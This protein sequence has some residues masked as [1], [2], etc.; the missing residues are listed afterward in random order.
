M[1]DRSVTVIAVEGCSLL[2]ERGQLFLVALLSF[3]CGRRKCCGAR[4]A[5]TEA[6]HPFR[7]R[8]RAWLQDVG[9]FD[10][11]DLV[12]PGGSDSRPSGPLDDRPLL[13]RFS[14]P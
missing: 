2:V 13:H 14:A 5:I 7:E 11:V 10:F 9:G 8:C 12:R 6:R 1:N 3:T 4:D